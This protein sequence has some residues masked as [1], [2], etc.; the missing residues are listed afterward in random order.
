[1]VASASGALGSLRLVVPR[2]RANSTG[3]DTQ[4]VARVE[5]RLPEDSRGAAVARRFTRAALAGWA[6]EGS[7]DDVVLVVSE[8]VTNALSHGHGAP[9]L[10]L[11]GTAWRVRVEV[12]DDSAL[13]PAIRDIGPTGG[14]GL[15]LVEQVAVD[16][17]VAKGPGG[18]VVWCE[19]RPGH[20][21]SFAS[22]ATVA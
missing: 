3:V 4:S 20:P 9:R 2:R 12:G 1:M 18:K 6:Y 7:H 15:R 10:V 17:G 16:W 14:W 21:P 8:L 13:A 5:T 22:R 11:A 19:L